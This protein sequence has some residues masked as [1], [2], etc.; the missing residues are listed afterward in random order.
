MSENYL[1]SK[2]KI[3][4]IDW[5][6]SIKHVLNKMKLPPLNENESSVRKN[7]RDLCQLKHNLYSCD[8]YYINS[9]NVK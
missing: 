1:M 2:Y 8:I 3:S 9:Y 5:S 4:H 7:V 6:L